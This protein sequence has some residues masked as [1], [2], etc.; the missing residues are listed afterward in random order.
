S[1]VIEKHDGHVA[2]YLGDGV[3]AYFGYPAAHEDDPERAVRTG[4]GIVDALLD[5]NAA[6]GPD[7]QLAVRIGIHTGPT[8]VS[9][10]GGKGKRETL[11]LGETTNVAARVQGAADPGTVV[12]TAATQRLVAGMFVVEE[13]GPHDLKG[14]R[15][16]V[17]LY[18]VVQPSGVRSRLNA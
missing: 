9:Q 11:A 6:L 4:L 8:V 13:R 12:I 17:V 18:R 2:Q 10:L 5:A 15:E 1:T 7:R 14:V 3:L 16:A